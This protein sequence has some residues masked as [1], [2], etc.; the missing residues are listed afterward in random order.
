MNLVE[1]VKKYHEAWN[2]HNPDAVSGFFI[3]NATYSDPSAGKVVKSSALAE[4]AKTMFTAFP[5]LTFTVTAVSQIGNS[6]IV[7]EYTIK[8]TN[9]GP[10]PQTP[11]SNRTI[12]IAAVDIIEFEAGKIKSLKGFYDRLT[13]AEQLGWIEG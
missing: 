6:K 9:T 5:D 1:T 12:S 7:L 3:E 11:P 10:L 4:Y 13:M 2:S 8:G